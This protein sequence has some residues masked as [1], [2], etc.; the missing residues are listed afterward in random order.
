MLSRFIMHEERREGRVSS[1]QEL[2]ALKAGVYIVSS[3]F[4]EEQGVDLRLLS[5]YEFPMLQLAPRY[6]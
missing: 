1:V 5:V 6:Q 3:F 2:S 4:K